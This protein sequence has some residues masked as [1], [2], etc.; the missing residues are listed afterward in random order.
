MKVMKAI[1]MGE[2]ERKSTCWRS[3]D[4]H[5]FPPVCE[6]VFPSKNLNQIDIEPHY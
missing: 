3:V 6:L 5:Q 4:S 1:C 2:V